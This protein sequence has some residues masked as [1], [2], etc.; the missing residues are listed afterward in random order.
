MEGGVEVMVNH[1]EPYKIIGESGNLI[2]EEIFTIDNEKDEIEEIG[3][4]DIA[5]FDVDFLG[6]IYCL[7]RKSNENF[8]FKFNKNADFII[9]FGRKGQGPGELQNPTNLIVVHK[10]NIVITDVDN[11]KVLIFG[12]D[13]KLIEESK[14]FTYIE[15]AIPLENNKYLIKDRTVDPTAKYFEHPLS[16][17]NSD[18]GEIKELELQKIPNPFIGERLKGTYH[19]MSWSISNG[20]IFTGFQERGY[21]IYVYNLEGNLLRKIRKEYNPVSVSDEYKKKYMKQF[22]RP[23]FEPIR[24]KIHFPDYMPPYHSFFTD[25]KG[26]LFVMTYEKGENPGE[27]MYDIFNSDGI[28]IGRKSLRI[29]HDANGLY[30]K[31]KDGRLYCLTEKE[32]GYKELKIYKVKWGK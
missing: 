5:C 30:A 28:F 26:M 4:T 24:K 18:F 6:N 16:L 17:C 11:S 23:I 31:I 3:L 7:N 2:L 25:D 22:E 20:K 12:E 15:T 8:I 9:F 1:L 27:Y 14:I 10:D 13:G 29:F 19:V 32:S 21:E